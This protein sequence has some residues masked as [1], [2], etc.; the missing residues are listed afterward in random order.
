M[1]FHFISSNSAEA[2][3]AKDEY[4]NWYSQT[5]PELSDIILSLIHI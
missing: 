5:D 3:K 1:K 4:I 2:I